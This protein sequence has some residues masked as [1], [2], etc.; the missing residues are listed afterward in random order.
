MLEWQLK[1]D[2][3]F[4]S[5]SDQIKCQR[6]HSVSGLRDIDYPM[7]EVGQNALPLPR[8][9]GIVYQTPPPHPVELEETFACCKFDARVQ[10]NSF[11]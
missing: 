9:V 3:Q 10:L 7:L 5:L 4:L 8:Q 2:E 1:N 6:C 11:Y